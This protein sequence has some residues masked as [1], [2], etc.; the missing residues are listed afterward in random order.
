M[1]MGA[2]PLRSEVRSGRGR[3]GNQYNILDV[4][5]Q[6]IPRI[7]R[8]AFSLKESRFDNELAYFRY[9]VLISVGPSGSNVLANDELKWRQAPSNIPTSKRNQARQ[10][11]L[12]PA[13]TDSLA[14]K[15]K[16]FELMSC[17]DDEA[18][19]GYSPR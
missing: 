18:T 4:L 9:D 13:L 14:V 16:A 3:V 10:T 19:G 12:G 7:S 2:T 8:V 15:V 17:L 6:Y 5:R 11:R 1:T